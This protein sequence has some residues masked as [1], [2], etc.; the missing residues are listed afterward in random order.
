MSVRLYVGNLPFEVTGAD[1]ETL[2]STIGV[3]EDAIIVTQ[4]GGG[5]PRGFG[6][7]E[8]QDEQDAHL[9]IEQL[10]GHPLAG[11]TLKVNVANTR[12]DD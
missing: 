6:F 10:D 8:M 9:A 11:R 3:V 4:P 7:V 2:F 12:D 1:L 5:R